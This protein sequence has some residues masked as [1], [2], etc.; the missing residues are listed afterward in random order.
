MYKMWKVGKPTSIWD[1]YDMQQTPYWDKVPIV[2]GMREKQRR[3]IIHDFLSDKS[4]DTWGGDRRSQYYGQLTSTIPVGAAAYL[5][6]RAL[7]RRIPKLK[8]TGN[9]SGLIVSGLAMLASYL[10][11]NAMAARAGDPTMQQ[12]YNIIN[13]HN[14]R[15]KNWWQPGHAAYE[16]EMLRRYADMVKDKHP[17]ELIERRQALVPIRPRKKKKGI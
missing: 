2:S 8:L 5:P 13:E 11:G 14:R 16:S 3:R 17:R 4:E 6:G 12:M 15:G 10:G 7:M 9:K 1:L